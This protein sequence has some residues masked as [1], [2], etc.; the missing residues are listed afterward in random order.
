MN[1]FQTIAF[2]L[3][4]AFFIGIAVLLIFMGDNFIV[5]YFRKRHRTHR[6]RSDN[7][8]LL[9][10]SEL[11]YKKSK[12]KIISKKIDNIFLFCLVI[13]FI[14]LVIPYDRVNIRG[15]NIRFFLKG[16][17][18]EGK[19]Y[20]IGYLTN[21]KRGISLELLEEDMSTPVKKIGFPFK[22]ILMY[23]VIMI[24]LLLI[25]FL[26]HFSGRYFGYKIFNIVTVIFYPFSIGYFIFWGNTTGEWVSP[27]NLGFLALVFGIGSLVV[28]IPFKMVMSRIKWNDTGSVFF[29]QFIAL[30][31]IGFIVGIIYK[32]YKVL[33]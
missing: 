32:F 9:D 14:Y 5:R 21:T 12:W 11:N 26:L 19:N 23:I 31:E 18:K 13:F 4:L 10:D 3:E 30:Y 20:R 6:K 28:F 27:H 24:C 15:R 25:Y 8:F 29:A 16:N 22:A 7:Y 33:I 1:V 17:L 2:V